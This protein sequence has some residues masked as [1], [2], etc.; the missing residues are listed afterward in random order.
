MTDSNNTNKTDSFLEHAFEST[1]W[2]S[3]F[4]VLFA[5]VA[6]LLT[7]IAM[8]YIATVDAWYMLIHLLEYAS[9]TLDTAARNHL[10]AETVTHVVEIVDGYLLAT[11]LLIF[12]LGL[13]ELFISKIDIASFSKTASN[14]LIINSLDDLKGR[15]AKVILMILIVRFFEY[16]IGMHIET[17][18]N[19]LYLAAGIALI[20]LALFL[21]HE[22]DKPYSHKSESG[23][24][25]QH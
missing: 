12:A 16:A 4:I 7:S 15:L 3:R 18:L 20:G 6:S 19:L 1:L 23:K 10:R 24:N 25:P 13:Y 22:S 9:P 5:V 14:V 8:F 11:V 21:T 2:N 17:A